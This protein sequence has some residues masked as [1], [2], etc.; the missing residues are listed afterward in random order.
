[1]PLGVPWVVTVGGF[2]V[3]PA[4]GLAASVPVGTT[5]VGPACPV[6]AAGVPVLVAPASG[7]PSPPVVLI[8]CPASCFFSIKVCS[9]ASSLA[10]FASFCSLD[11]GLTGV[12]SECTPL[13][14][15]AFCLLS[16]SCFLATNPSESSEGFTTLVTASGTSFNSSSPSFLTICTSGGG[17]SIEGV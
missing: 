13:A 2:P 17:W 7:A 3:S 9:S 15:S 12:P 11:L 16:S 14:R 8:G 5:P 1:M 4:T 10:I 6:P